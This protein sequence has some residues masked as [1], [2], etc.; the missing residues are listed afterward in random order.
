ME[1]AYPKRMEK[2]ENKDRK[3]S[4]VKDSYLLLLLQK[5][6]ETDFMTGAKICFQL[7]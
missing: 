5:V 6:T 1:P 2:S 3:I 7:L 4:H